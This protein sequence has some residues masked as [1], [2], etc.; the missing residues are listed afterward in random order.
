MLTSFSR[1]NRLLAAL[2]GVEYERLRP[3]LEPMQFRAGKVLYEIDDPIRYV[4]FP[5]CGMVSLLAMAEAG[6]VVE[7]GMIGNEGLTGLPVL[8][9]VN[10]MPYRV[11]AQLAADT[12]R[13][14]TTVLIEEFRCG[15]RLY[16]L[17]LQYLY[18]V[19]KQIT[20][21]ALCYRFHTTEARLCR[22]LLTARGCAQVDSFHLTQESLAHMLGVP[23]TSVTMIA[24]RL[25]QLELIR[26][27]RGRITI[28][29]RQGL[30]AA[31]CECYRVITQEIDRYLVA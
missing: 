31:A 6:G 20:Q 27:S 21:S 13:L 14:K 25:Q 15:A 8:L 29:D 23:R 26:Y 4:Y 7:V 28:L 3:H 17:L 10:R 24:G 9:N 18:T 11:T 19:L 22:W 2:P 5:T 1:R 30:A 12:L 16:D